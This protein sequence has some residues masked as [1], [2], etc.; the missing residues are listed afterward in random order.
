MERRTLG[1]GGL[2][3]S[4][5]G[6]GCMG[7]SEFYGASDEAESIATIHRALDLGV[8]FLDTA[9]MYGVGHNEELV[10]RALKG[11]RDE[12]VIA[13]KFG[14]VRGPNG[15][16]LGISGKPDYV[17]SACEASLKRLGVEVIDLYYQHRVD[18]NTPIEDTVGAMAELV[19]AGQGAPSRPLRGGAADDPPRPCGA[20]D[21][22]AAD[23]IFAV[24]PRPGG[25]DPADRA[26]ARHRLRALCAARAR[27]PD[28]P[29]QAAGGSAGGRFPPQLAALVGREFPEEPRPRRARWRRSRARRAARR[30]RWRSPGCWRRATTSCRSPGTRSPT[31]LEENAGAAR[32]SRFR[33]TTSAASTQAFP[34]GAAIGERYAEGGM[35]TV[36]L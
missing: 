31:R 10:G 12:V 16:R 26:G 9:D 21:R 7:M 18:P 36:N 29:L 25:R 13:T 33:R 27:L 19:R 20:S 34:R 1:T 32:R 15:E 17:R 5:I 35:K 22:R 23:R 30:R 3:V 4:A 14:N 24:E 6:L 2:T 28:R 11:R 8:D